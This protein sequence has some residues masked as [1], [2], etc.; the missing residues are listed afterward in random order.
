MNKAEFLAELGNRL[1]VL[2]EEE[3]QDI[4]NEYEQH[5]DMK[6]MRGMSEE[7]ATADFGRMEELAADILEAYHVRA[8][9]AAA[10]AVQ[11]NGRKGMFGKKAQSGFTAGK[12]DNAA[13]EDEE[14]SGFAGAMAF[15]NRGYERTWKGVVSLWGRICGWWKG[16]T[17][18]SGRF[19][20]KTGKLLKEAAAELLSFCR[21]PFLKKQKADGTQD[22]AETATEAL[23]REPERIRTER[24]QRM[25]ERTGFSIGGAVLGACRGCVRAVLW[26]LKW[27]WNLMCIGAG[28]LFGGSSCL[29]VFFLGVIVVLLML[30]YPLAG[31]MV[32]WLGLTMCMVSVTAGCFSMMIGNRNRHVRIWLGIFAA[33]VLL[34]GV[35]TGIAFGEYSGLEYRGQ[36]LLGQE[37]LVTREFEY[38]FA[39]EDGKTVL[40]SYCHW[41]DERKDSLLVS[42]PSVPEREVRYVVTYNEEMVRPE[43]TDWEQEL[44]GNTWVTV[45]EAR[46]SEKVILEE[47]TYETFPEGETASQEGTLTEEEAAAQEKNPRRAVLELRSSWYGDEFDVVMRSKDRILEDL[48]EKKLG[49]YE[50]AGITEVEIRVNPQTLEYVED[51]TR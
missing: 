43:L 30:G 47:E 10:E 51:R 33:G 12:D 28:V 26:C 44:E 40:L 21:S 20:R 36:V 17:G 16:M 4:L 48:K 14:K 34:G 15:L 8:D 37:N 32:G 13:A 49:S 7:A 18:A 45:Q 46:D 27:M 42:D 11:G 9:Y 19:L 39:P 41:G 24:K 29:T 3:R 22:S 1:A 23:G 6:V 2:S 25:K 38:A 35:G 5:I 31:V 50:V